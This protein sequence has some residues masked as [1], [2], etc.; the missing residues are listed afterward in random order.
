MYLAFVV[1]NLLFVSVNFVVECVFVYLG[2]RVCIWHLGGNAWYLRVIF[3]YW[4]CL[5]DIENTGQ[6][7]SCAHKRCELELM[8]RKNYFKIVIHSFII[9]RYTDLLAS[10]I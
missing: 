8:D 1:V 5:F 10:F 2:M 7:L 6:V 9:I 3:C 4:F